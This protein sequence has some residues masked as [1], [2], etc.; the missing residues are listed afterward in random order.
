M[1]EGERRRM[2][3]M[4]DKAKAEERRARLPLLQ[5]KASRL[6][7]KAEDLKEQVD[8]AKCRLECVTVYPVTVVQLGSLKWVAAQVHRQCKLIYD[9]QSRTLR[10]LSLR[11]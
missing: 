6:A 5:L 8:P 7:K 4:G 11:G 3:I 2:E 9:A 10:E 1:I